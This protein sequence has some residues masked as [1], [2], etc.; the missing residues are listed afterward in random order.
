MGLLTAANPRNTGKNTLRHF[1]RLLCLCVC[2]FAVAP[3]DAMMVDTFNAEDDLLRTS[4]RS[5]PTSGTDVTQINSLDGTVVADRL[6][7]VTSGEVS[8]TGTSLNMPAGSSSTIDYTFPN[9]IDF[10][11][12]GDNAFLLDFVLSEGTQAEVI[13]SVITDEEDRWD[14]EP[15]FFP[16]PDG[17]YPAAFPFSEAGATR[18]GRIQRLF[19]QVT[20][21]SSGQNTFSL[22]EFGTAF[23]VP[24]PPAVFLFGSALGLLGWCGRKMR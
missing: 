23:L 1:D 4:P 20:T 24:L 18:I 12:Q 16:G 6:I 11:S 7:V 3:A 10:A 22:D 14:Y 9:P 2:L 19:L 13:L 8:L 21:S 17:Q 5:V 15:S